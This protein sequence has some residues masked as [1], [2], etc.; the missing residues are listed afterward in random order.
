M[1]YLHSR[2]TSRLVLALIPVLWTTSVSAQNPQV[3]QA[4]YSI[5]TLLAL[6][7]DGVEDRLRGK[8]TLN[9]FEQD[10]LR[11]DPGSR[12]LI[13][14]ADGI[15][16]ALNENTTLQILSRWDKANGTT[17]IVRV[18][19]GEVWVSSTGGKPMEIETST[20]TATVQNAEV[21][22][23]VAADGQSLLSVIQGNV[24]FATA[25]GWCT[26]TPSTSTSGARG[27]GCSPFAKVNVQ[28]VLAWSR[29][30]VR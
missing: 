20:G 1:T 15:R 11:T 2:L 29:E 10:V 30:L 25:Y 18:K 26:V 28:Q 23:K 19:R 9:L 3:G 22:F 4:Q 6:R 17:R 21:D 12:G 14:F 16:M 27:R 13:S 8:G 7:P 24:Q 5:G